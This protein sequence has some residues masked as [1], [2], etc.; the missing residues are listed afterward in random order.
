MGLIGV[1][2]VSERRAAQLAVQKSEAELRRVLGS[3][4]AYLWSADFDAAGR[5][6]AR[7]YSS[8]VERVTGRPAEFFL[9]AAERWLSTLHP[10]DLPRVRARY[11]ALLRGALDH[12][13]NEFRMVRPDGGTVWVH[14]SVRVHTP[15]GGG[16]RLDGVVIDVTERRRAQEAAHSSEERFRAVVE[17]IADGVALLSADGVITYTSRAAAPILGHTPEEMTGRVFLDL[18]HPDDRPRC[19]DLFA[20]LLARPGPPITAEFRC[21]HKDGSWRL[22]EATGKNRLGDPAVRAVVTTFRDVTE[23][24]GL[25]AQLRH[26]QKMEAVGQLAGGLAHDFNNLLTAMLGNLSLLLSGLAEGDPNREFAAGAERAAHRAANLTGQLLGFSRRTVLRPRPWCLNATVDEVLAILRR[27]LDPRIELEVRPAAELGTVEADPGQMTQ[28][29]LNLCLNARD[30]MPDG[31]RL[32]IE[33]ADVT[34]EDARGRQYLGAGPGRFVRLRVGDT[35]GGMPAEVRDRIFEPFFTTK[36]PGRGTGLGLAMVFGIVRQHSGWVECA[37]EVGRGTRFD[38]YLPRVEALAEAPTADDTPPAAGH[39]TVLLV[40][41]EEM[42][43]T[44]G[45][46]ILQRY[47]YEVLLAEDGQQAVD[48]Y[49][50]QHERIDLVILDLTMPHLSGHDAFRRLLEIDPRARVLFA[51]GYSAERLT[52]AD[53]QRALGFVS[54]PYRSEDLARAVRTALDLVWPRVADPRGS[55]TRG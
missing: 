27:T 13:E 41:D 14:T 50:E 31:G 33:T 36:G 47:G 51:S 42:I 5:P 8:D 24:R 34:I 28:V 30:A 38:V 12:D 52:D 39:E 22:I 10:D 48:V 44:V 43:R 29:L 55:A 16:R 35:G 4:S 6:R 46:A 23:R 54:K 11:E 37:S 1:R 25:E 3:A 26:A 19:G 53:Q 20:V 45:S 21:R 18:I 49:R 40:D 17:Q 9:P 32:T 7:Y 15:A 2:G